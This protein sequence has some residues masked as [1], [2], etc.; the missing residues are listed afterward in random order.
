MPATDPIADML[1]SIRNAL[2]ARHRRVDIPSSRMKRAIAEVLKAEKY[3]EN[4][5]VLPDQKHETLRIYLRYN[6]DEKPMIRTLKRISTPGRRVYV[7]R[8]EIPRVLGG[9]GTA[10]LSTPD[11]VLTGQEATRRGL[12]GEL[13]AEIW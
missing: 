10:I 7:K 13:V 1:T 8:D 6:A 3:I 2:M 4:F 5:K 9:L 11:G 12:G